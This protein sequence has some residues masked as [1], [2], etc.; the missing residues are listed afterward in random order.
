ML[1]CKAGSLVA[2]IQV[3]MNLSIQLTQN[4]FQAGRSG[5][6][7]AA[8]AG[9]PHRTQNCLKDFTVGDKQRCSKGPAH[10]RKLC[11]LCVSVA[12]QVQV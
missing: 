12:L 11:R 9:L 10:L 4:C 1:V 3:W 6:R 5:L 7:G 2:V 8:A